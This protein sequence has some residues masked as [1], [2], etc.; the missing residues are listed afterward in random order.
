MSSE[1]ICCIDLSVRVAQKLVQPTS[2][3]GYCVVVHENQQRRFMP[4]VFCPW[5]GTDLQPDEVR[6]YGITYPAG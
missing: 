3:Y 6:Q 1:P 2:G 5:C 4:I